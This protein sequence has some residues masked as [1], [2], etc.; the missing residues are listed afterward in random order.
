MGNIVIN[1]G[2]PIKDCPTDWEEAEAWA[3]KANGEAPSGAPQW[4][5]DCGFKLDYDLSG[6]LLRICSRFYPPKTG[7]GPT[8]D[9]TLTLSVRDQV[10]KKVGYDCE[11][12]EELRKQVEKF[13][14]GVV[15]KVDQHC[16]DRI[17]TELEG[18]L[19]L[20]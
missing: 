11:T 14:H 10:L 5:F 6:D 1:G 4:R 15:A 3:E 8:W 12:L 13:A 2:D 18:I 17:V 9:G 19:Q 16:Y 20:G 7:Y